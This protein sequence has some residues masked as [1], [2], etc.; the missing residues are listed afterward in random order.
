MDNKLNEL[1]QQQL[2]PLIN[3]SNN[4]TKELDTFLDN[5]E[6]CMKLASG[7]NNLYD[8]NILNINTLL[9]TLLIIITIIDICINWKNKQ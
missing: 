1:Q 6:N 4:Q 2:E 5:Y 9:L 7:N 3:E 8:N